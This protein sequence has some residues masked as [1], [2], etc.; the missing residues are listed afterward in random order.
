[1][2]LAAETVESPMMVRR[3]RETAMLKNRLTI[4]SVMSRPRH[5]DFIT[6]LGMLLSCTP[7][8]VLPCGIELHSDLDCSSCALHLN[9]GDTRSF[10]VSALPEG[11]ES[12]QFISG[13]EF[14]IVGLPDTWTYQIVPNPASV[15]EGD[16]LGP[17]GASV[18]F[19]SPPHSAAECVLLYTIVVTATTSVQD[20]VLNVLGKP[21]AS[22][23]CPFVRMGCTDSAC[24]VLVCAETTSLFINSQ[25]E[26]STAVAP[27][28]WQA[29]KQLFE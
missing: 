12:N 11:F 9:V 14:R 22:V 20:L 10:Y 15:S 5:T 24:D 23:G 13:S 25:S 2:A 4:A 29:I 26:C 27:V 16:P 28:S 18:H 7:S 1:V 3:T 8:V 19:P 21:S 17:E 6:A